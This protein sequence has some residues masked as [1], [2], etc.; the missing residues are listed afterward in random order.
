M[1]AD[2]WRSARVVGRMKTSVAVTTTGM[3][4][5]DGVPYALNSHFAEM[6]AKP[7]A[8][9]FEIVRVRTQ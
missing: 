9:A 6:T 7:Q 1:S 8:A 4:L 3:T 2:G 5:R